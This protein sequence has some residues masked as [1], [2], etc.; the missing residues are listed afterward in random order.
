MLRD[1]PLDNLELR[2]HT[3]K[4]AIANFKEAL[5]DL[6]LF[7]KA[8]NR[9]E[10]EYRKERY[11]TVKCFEL[12]TDTLWKYLKFYLQESA[13]VVHNSPKAVMRECF[14]ED[15]IDE[16]ETALAIKMIDAR[17][18]ATHI[19]RELVAEQL[20]KQLPTFY[21]VMHK[22]IN[23]AIPDKNN[24]QTTFVKK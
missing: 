24:T 7:L 6:E 14:R 10:K 8:A 17:N 3:T 11:S 12:A 20:I 18:E 2:H 15:L 5:D 13:G 19:Y 23:A 4:R 22:L 1:E 16:A 9:T 21:H